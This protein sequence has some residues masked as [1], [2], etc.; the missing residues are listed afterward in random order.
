MT[1]W[2]EFLKEGLDPRIQKQLN[3]L[4]ALEDI[5]IVLSVFADGDGAEIRYVRIEDYEN[6]QFSELAESEAGVRQNR[7]VVK[8]GKNRYK[9]KGFA[10]ARKNKN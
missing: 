7:K 2:R 8:T 5:G 3:T 6:K 9:T 10:W 4:L 1:E